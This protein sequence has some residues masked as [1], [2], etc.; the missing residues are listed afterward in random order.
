MCLVC[1]PS[2]P[3]RPASGGRGVCMCLLW[4]VFAGTLGSRRPCRPP[5]SPGRGSVTA[6]PVGS[7]PSLCPFCVHLTRNLR[8]AIRTSFWP[9][10]SLAS[11]LLSRRLHLTCNYVQNLLFLPILCTLDTHAFSFYN[12]YVMGVAVGFAQVSSV[13]KMGTPSPAAVS[14]RSAV[15]TAP[16][17]G[18]R[19]R[20]TDY[21]GV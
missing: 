4:S 9:S 6:V 14:A 8:F 17:P 15:I 12:I 3:S 21:G 5:K 19:A 13:H 18:F 11:V 20:K 10:K 7:R 1:Q 16:G 2:G